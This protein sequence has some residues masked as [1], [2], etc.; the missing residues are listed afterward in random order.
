MPEILSVSHML[1]FCDLYHILK[2]SAPNDD[3]KR[4]KAF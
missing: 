3:T 2:L 4:E 1:L